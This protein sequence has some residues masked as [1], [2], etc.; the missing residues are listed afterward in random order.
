M[1]TFMFPFSSISIG[2]YGAEVHSGMAKVALHFF[3]FNLFN[4][5]GIKFGGG[6]SQLCFTF[7]VNCESVNT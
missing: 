1:K 7:P 3:C 5:L 2:Q 6:T 4:T